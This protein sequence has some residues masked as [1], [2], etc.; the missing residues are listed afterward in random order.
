M[1]Q[2]PDEHREHL[3]NQAIK[4]A[5]ELIKRKETFPFP[6]IKQVYYDRCK[7]E[8]QKLIDLGIGIDDFDPIDTA[9]ENF[10]GQGIEVCIGNNNKYIYIIPAGSRDNKSST[11]PPRYLD[12]KDEMNPL[13]KELI[14]LDSLLKLN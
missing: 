12:I 14:E 1:K 5:T 3:L 13:L 2:S 6:G 4:I 10:R 11:I 9:L 7:E 8:E